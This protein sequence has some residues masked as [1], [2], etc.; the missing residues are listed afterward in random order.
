MTNI[1]QSETIGGVAMADKNM[2]YLLFNNLSLVCI[3]VCLCVC[4]CL[5]LSLSLSL[6]VSMTSIYQ[7]TKDMLQILLYRDQNVAE[8]YVCVTQLRINFFYSS[9]PLPTFLQQTYVVDRPPCTTFIELYLHRC[10]HSYRNNS[11]LSLHLT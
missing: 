9:L 10:Q 7:F 1:K 2:D 3:C 8:L 6:F 5:S 4:V 11:W